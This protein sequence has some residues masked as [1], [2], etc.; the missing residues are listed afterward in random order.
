MKGRESGM[1]D[2]WQCDEFFDPAK[3]IEILGCTNSSHYPSSAARS[4]ILTANPSKHR[5]DAILSVQY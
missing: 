3:A 1:P 2:E 4:A 5:S